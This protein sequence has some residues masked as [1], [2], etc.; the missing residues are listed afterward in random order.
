VVAAAAALGI[1][2]YYHGI[3]DYT[4][5]RFFPIEIQHPRAS[6]DW[7]PLSTAFWTA[8]TWHI[9]AWIISLGIAGASWSALVGVGRIRAFAI[10]HL[11][12]TAL[13]AGVACWLVFLTTT[14]RGSF[15]VYFET[16]IWPFALIFAAIAVA[17]ALRL[18]LSAIGAGRRLLL[19]RSRRGA[20]QSDT[21]ALST[22]TI[23]RAIGCLSTRCATLVLLG[24]IA[25]IAIRNT[26]AIPTSNQ[27]GISGS[28]S[29]SRPTVITESLA[30]E[31]GLR[32]GAR[33]RGTVATFDDA[34]A[35][36]PGDWIDFFGHDDGLWQE[37]GN[38]HRTVGLWSFGIPTLFQ[39][40][41]FI[42]PP[43]YLLLT[44]FLSDP[45]DHQLRSVIVMTH[46]DPAFLA[47]W[48]V[49]FVITD[50]EAQ[51]GREVVTMPT[52]HFGTLRL[53]ELPDPNLGDYS[54]VE[55]AHADDFPA[56]LRLMHQADFDARRVVVTE[57][58][59]EQP[60]V[61][62]VNAELVYD[63]EGLRLKAES[64]G[65]SVIVLPAQYSHCWTAGGAGEPRLFRANVGQL[66][67]SFTAK[68]DAKL[69]FR[70]GPILAGGC[71]VKDLQDMERLRISQSREA[72][73][74]DNPP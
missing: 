18:L 69:V 21:A 71:R 17:T 5:F 13:Y 23:G 40:H 50:R 74:G 55:V 45:A 64:N 54:P 47:L 58:R 16:G 56:A 51:P 41:T 7:A 27:C 6:G 52:K 4:A 66:G 25:A 2:T 24:L 48:G 33:F 15:P 62:A 11:I 53:L 70:L 32:A 12:A 72:P 26:A 49:R 29:P 73:R 19:W 57:E 3:I 43:Y 35:G 28:F 46:I 67:V 59:F 68:L 22:D 31:I 60:L 34:Q 37:I 42:T 36:R 30:H 8:T 14:Y 1:L 44:D 9:G 61:P 10:T 65:H 20:S 38:E 63:K 39:Y